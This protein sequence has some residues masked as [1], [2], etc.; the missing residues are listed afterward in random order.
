VNTN[1][2]QPDFKK[3]GRLLSLVCTL[4]PFG[5]LS[6][7]PFLYLG[8]K[9]KN[10]NKLKWAIVYFLLFSLLSVSFLVAIY[11]EGELMDWVIVL[12][13]L[14]CW[15]ASIIHAVVTFILNEGEQKTPLAQRNFSNF[16]T[17]DQGKK[18]LVDENFINEVVHEN[19]KLK[20]INHKLTEQLKSQPK[21][22]SIASN[23]KLEL[24][25]LKEDNQRLRKRIEDLQMSS[26]RPERT[27]TRVKI[28]NNSQ[29]I[30]LNDE[31]ELKKMGYQ[32]TGLS[33][34]KRWGILEKA[35]P[36][37]G[38]RSV[39]NT[40]DGNI[41][42]RVKQVDGRR[43]YSNAIKAWNDDL[44]KLKATYYKDDF[45]WPPKR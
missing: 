34:Q 12:I 27:N 3:F 29:G 6:F 20:E 5:F 9:N 28:I 2:L 24:L 14:I 44:Q 45:K 25:R 36:K 7:V 32:I 22:D 26:L 35:V 19:Q 1:R 31:S 30:E 17:N 18:E 37:L 33:S 41:A 42:L 15:I 23:E 40:I 4:F 16:E 8:L 39:I 38:L 21:V 43:K 11:K 10:P 13:M